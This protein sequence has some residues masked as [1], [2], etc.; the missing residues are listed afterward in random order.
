MSNKSIIASVISGTI[1]IFAFPP[2]DIWVI[3]WFG[4]APLFFA[5]YDKK[6]LQAF[7]LGFIWGIVFFLGTVY[8]V[9]NSMVNYG[10]VPVWA[11][12]LA[13]LLLVIV[14]SLYP[15][16]FA[17]F[18]F[19]REK[20]AFHP[21]AFRLIFIP[22]L[23]VSLEFVRTYLFTGFPWVLLGYS[24]T[25]FLPIMQIADITG[26]YGVSFLIIMVNVFLFNCGLQ[27]ADCGFKIK[28]S[29][30]E[31]IIVFS[32]LIL[33][34]GYGHLRIGQIDNLTKNWRQIK[35]GI[36]Q[37]NID[38]A[39]KW[40]PA[41]QEGTIDI[42]RQISIDIAQN[43][44]D[45][46]LIIWPETATPFYL[47]SDEKFGPLIFDIAKTLAVNLITGSPAHEYTSDGKT[48]NYYNSVFLISKQG[49]IVNRYDKVHLVPFGEYVPFKR[50]L[51]FE[52]LVAGVGDFSSGKNFKPL[53]LNNDDTFGILICFEAIF[54]DIARQ[55]LKN[56]ADFLITV[57]NDA[58][59]G[60]SSAPYQ[61]LSQ[62][63]VRAVEGRTFLIRSAN[64]GISA[65]IDPVGRIKVK[66]GLFTREGLVD[67]IS[68]KER[69]FT[70]FY[71]RYGDVFAIGCI[72]ISIVIFI[73][74]ARKRGQTC[75]L[76]FALF[77]FSITFFTSAVPFSY[78]SY[79]SPF[80]VFLL[81]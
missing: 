41:H 9:V 81:S 65:V 3:G 28:I 70:T 16:V 27:I 17:Y 39:Q 19:S 40:D 10:G 71:T 59:F 63:L 30:M 64:T 80:L 60:R 8:W 50:F 25:A 37:G 58:W 15:A 20:H 18:T 46:D 72:F 38:Q 49:G 77:I 52:K 56:G 24:Q 36:A 69:S 11:S 42:Y 73:T 53:A 35:I 31:W 45:I 1:M 68:L 6:P 78:F 48:I 4:M 57:T 54:P 66:S 47:Q 33:V 55:L 75:L 7:A 29:K 43:E 62:S 74:N 67:T 23:W 5:I 44:K 32:V 79:W 51:P 21:S 34:F 13:L 14:L 22:F 76:T 26:V 12:V 61:H 2:F